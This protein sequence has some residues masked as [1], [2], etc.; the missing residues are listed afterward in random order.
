MERHKYLLDI[1]TVIC[2]GLSRVQFASFFMLYSVCVGALIDDVQAHWTFE[3]PEVGLQI[4][5][6]RQL[7]PISYKLRAVSAS[8][9]R[10]ICA[11]VLHS[12]P[13][14]VFC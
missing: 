13:L 3:H 12:N 5:A 4:A 14:C 2:I 9:V 8:A 11:H 1:Q 10:D 7:S 6:L